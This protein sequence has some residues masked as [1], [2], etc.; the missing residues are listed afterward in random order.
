MV[1]GGK[2][3]LSARIY[4]LSAYI[5]CRDTLGPLLIAR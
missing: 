3:L 2:L 4:A 5:E 1:A